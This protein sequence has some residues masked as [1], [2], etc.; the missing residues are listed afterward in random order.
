MQRDLRILVEIRLCFSPG[1]EHVPALDPRLISWIPNLE[2][3]R[4]RLEQATEEANER[5]GPHTHW[6]QERQA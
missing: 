5:Y 4:V 2:R 3:N 1:I 6:I